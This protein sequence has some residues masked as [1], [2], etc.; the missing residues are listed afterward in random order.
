MRRFAPDDTAKVDSSVEKKEV[1]PVHTRSESSQR[2]LRAG[3]TC[4]VSRDALGRAA[5]HLST[6]MR[7]STRSRS[8]RAR[9]LTFKLESC[10]G[11]MRRS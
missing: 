1:R 5:F 8:R 9:S 3:L 6:M 7:V 4:C 11:Y 10:S 2:S